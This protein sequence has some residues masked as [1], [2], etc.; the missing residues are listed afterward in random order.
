[1][2]KSLAF[3]HVL[4]DPFHVCTSNNFKFWPLKFSG[5]SD[6]KSTPLKGMGRQVWQ[7]I[8]RFLENETLNETLFC[9]ALGRADFFAVTELICRCGFQV[10]HCNTLQHAATRCLQ[11][12]ALAFGHI[13][14]AHLLCDNTLRFAAARCNTLQHTATHCN[15]LQHNVINCN[16]LQHA[17]TRCNTINVLS[18]NEKQAP[19]LCCRHTRNM[20]HSCE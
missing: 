3:R 17:A 18:K 20:T 8:E 4:H 19:R 10:I 6:F 13:L 11:H 16:M 2:P 15:T 7:Q 9:S 1:V 5:L 12:A 14:H